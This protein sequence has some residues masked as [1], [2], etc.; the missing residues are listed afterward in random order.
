MNKIMKIAAIIGGAALLTL[1]LSACGSSATPI[2]SCAFIVGDGDN[3]NDANIHKISLP[4]EN[5]TIGSD[6]KAQYVPCGPRNYEM[7]D[8]KKTNANNEKIGDFFTPVTA[9]TSTGTQVKVSVKVYFTLNESDAAMRAFYPLC[10][11]HTCYSSESD[12][13][14]K[15]NSATPGWNAMLGENF[16][17]TITTLIKDAVR[18]HDDTIWRNQDSKQWVEV[19]EQSAN[20]FAEAIRPKVGSQE[21]VFCGIGNSGW[22]DPKKPGKGEFTCGNVF[23]EVLSLDNA[24]KKT[25]N[26]ESDKQA[27]T[28][29]QEVNAAQLEAAKA[30]YG[31]QAEYWLGLQ[32][33][34]AKCK[35][36]GSTCVVN[37]GS[38]NGTVVPVPAPS[39]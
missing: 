20:G 7:N 3:G 5:I 8:G 38:G 17:D 13:G 30:R 21:N 34:I 22:A 9:T 19:A 35:D 1:G 33:A 15:V 16:P 4:G 31:D 39:K 37:M 27:A 25:Q 36:A 28:L 12:G 24:D 2:G 29:Q 11:K 18:T 14:K 6:E 32:D 23:F 26:L 10:Y